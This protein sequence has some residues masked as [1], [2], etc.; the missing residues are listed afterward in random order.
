M[1][2]HIEKAGMFCFSK[3]VVVKIFD[4]M[5]NELD[6][7]IYDWQL[8]VESFGEAGQEQLRNTTALVS[9]IGGLGGV[10]AFQLAAAGIGKLVLAHAGNLRKDDLNRQILMRWDGLNSPRVE[11]AVKTLSAFNPNIEVEVHD[12]NIEEA[13]VTELVDR[14]DIVFSCA[15]LFEER[16]LMNRECVRQGKPMIDC[17]MFNLEG[18]VFPIAPGQTP[19]LACLFPEKPPHWKRKFPVFGAV[20][21]LIG[22]MGVMEGLKL[23]TGFGESN[24]GKMIVMDT[25]RMESTKVDVQCREGCSICR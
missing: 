22:C 23:L 9:R 17:A 4:F 12:T 14:S 24:I 10:V 25:A 7:T 8:E 6:R 16:F 2:F 20:S 1:S 19:C 15:P 21:A 3:P 5:L 13:N 18:H 11:S